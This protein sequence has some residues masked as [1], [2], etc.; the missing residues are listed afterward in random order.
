MSLK[1]G[2]VGLPNVGKSTLFNALT[3][4]Q[5]A[6]ENFAF[7]T[8]DPHTGVVNI[9]DKRLQ[10]LAELVQPRKTV[11]ATMEF[12]DIAGLVEGASQG[13]GLGNQFLAHIRE[14]HAIAHILRGFKNEDIVHIHQK[15][16]PLHDMEIINT[17]LCL[18]DLAVAEKT[19]TKHQRKAG[20]GDKEAQQITKL[21]QEKVLPCL[22]AGKT[23]RSIPWT[24]EEASLMRP[25]CFLTLK[26]VIYVINQSDDAESNIETSSLEEV[27][28]KEGNSRIK[29]NVRLEEELTELEDKEREAFLQELGIKE[30]ALSRFIRCA[31][32][33]LSLHNFFTAEEKEARAWTIPQGTTAQEAAGVIHTD[34]ARLFIRA[35]VIG[36]ED[37]IAQGGEQ[38][39]KKQGLWRLEGKDYLVQDG[40]VIHFRTNA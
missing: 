19:L 35:E 13:E 36:Y 5:V 34:F 6:A 27:I 22:N 33:L 12:V 37:F 30:A 29:I 11:P 2:L 24:K 3:Q 4:A 15:M 14:T 18:A 38:G 9:P 20:S 16:D 25:F 21:L 39:A 26:P 23:L 8:V 28:R 32:A 40:D 17:E 7:C 31:Y 10:Q 1:C